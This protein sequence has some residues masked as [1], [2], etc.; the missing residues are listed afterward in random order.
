MSHMGHQPTNDSRQ[1]IQGEL[2]ACFSNHLFPGQDCSITSERMSPDKE[3]AEVVIGVEDDGEGGNDHARD[4]VA[5]AMNTQ[6]CAGSRL[7]P[8]HASRLK[9]CSRSKTWCQ[10]LLQRPQKET[11]KNYERTCGTQRRCVVIMQH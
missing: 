10:F 9:T 8:V 7:T 11:S 1:F 6:R 2:Q 3:V 5:A 4:K